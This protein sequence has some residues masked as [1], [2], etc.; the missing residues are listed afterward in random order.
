MVNKKIDDMKEDIVH[1]SANPSTVVCGRNI[2]T[3]VRSP[4]KPH[5]IIWMLFF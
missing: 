4:N 1:M 5:S 3:K 2:Q